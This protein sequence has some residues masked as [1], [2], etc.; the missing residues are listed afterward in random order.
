[1]IIFLLFLEFYQETFQRAVEDED[2]KGF[3]VLFLVARQ[4]T[5][6]NRTVFGDYATWLVSLSFT[7]QFLI[8]N[9][10]MVIKAA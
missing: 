8:F 10:Q 9:G 4:L 3:H 5:Q 2:E 1:M 6:Y 7:K